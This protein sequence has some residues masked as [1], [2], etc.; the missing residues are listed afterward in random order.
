FMKLKTILK[1][2]ASF[3][4]A[5][6]LSA[7]AYG[8]QIQGTID[9]GGGITLNSSNLPGSTGGYFTAGLVLDSTGDFSSVPSIPQITAVDFANDTAGNLWHWESG[10][11]EDFWQ[12]G[13]F[14]FD[15][16][17]STEIATGNPNQALAVLGQGVISGNGFD[18]TPGEWAFVVS[19]AGGGN[20]GDGKFTFQA[21]NRAA[22]AVPDGGTSIA[23]LGVALLGLHSIRR[24]MRF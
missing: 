24:K 19:N 8:A 18:P 23:L 10:P 3:L 5:F 21:S 13:G 2:A 12:V 1:S 9:F 16:L 4:T 22:P 11:V 17:S 15:L 7:M 20:R 14:T 6:G